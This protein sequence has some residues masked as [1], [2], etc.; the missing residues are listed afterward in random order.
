[1]IDTIFIFKCVK[2]KLHMSKVTEVTNARGM[3]GQAGFGIPLIFIT[4]VMFDI[5][6][7]M[8]LKLHSQLDESCIYYV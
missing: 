7:L 1:M 8:D 5:H 2:F 3:M 6:V 4:V